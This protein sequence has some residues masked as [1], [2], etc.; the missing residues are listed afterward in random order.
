ML[1]VKTRQT[2]VGLASLIALG[3]A[4]SP[5][6][7]AVEADVHA[8]VVASYEGQRL[9]DQHKLVEADEQL[10]LC[11]R[12]GCP[13]PIRSS[14]LDWRAEVDA[15]LPSVIV[16]AR[17]TSGND[18]VDVRVSADG[19]PVA[20]RLDGT[21][22]VLDPGPHLL[23]FE[24]AS[25]APVEQQI[26]VRESEKNRLLAVV[27]PSALPVEPAALRPATTSSLAAVPTV[28]WVMAGV[29]VAGLGTFAYFGITGQS[30][31]DDLSS[32][33]AS[34]RTCNPASVATTHTDLAV[35]DV[36]L[37]VALTALV[38]GAVFVIAHRGAR[39]DLT[40]GAYPVVVF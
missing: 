38:T 4:H 39:P 2:T 25:R 14:C 34:S 13:G 27:L 17:D 26:V 20:S 31:R 12:E 36:A 32:T 24:A 5:E 18:L 8:C 33:C 40:V 7:Y 10:A 30:M 21:G 16:A 22:I 29:G 28:S 37:A 15:L 3:A 6:A 19:K 23:R 9:R 1:S 11:A 35:A